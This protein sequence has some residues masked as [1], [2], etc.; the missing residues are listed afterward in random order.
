MWYSPSTQMALGVP[1]CELLMQTHWTQA[2]RW[3]CQELQ[4]HGREKELM[5]ALT[6]WCFLLLSL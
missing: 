5:D 6:L 3:L 4:A 1:E 2:K